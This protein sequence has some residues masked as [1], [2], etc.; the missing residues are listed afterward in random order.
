ALLSPPCASLCLQGALQAL[1]HS[2]SAATE[3]LCDAVIGHFVPPGPAPASGESPLVT[4]LEDAEQGRVLEAAL[5][6]AVP[7]QL[8]ELFQDH[9]R[10]RLRGVACHRLANHGLQ[11]LLDHA[12]S[13]VV[14][15]VLEE[16]GPALHEP[17]ARGHHGVAVALVAAC[18]RHPELQQGALR[19]VL[20][21]GRSSCRTLWCHKAPPSS[22]PR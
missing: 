4:A 3:H 2:Q 17:L 8:R 10:G 14:G 21:V 22:K 11:R 13:D 5:A 19:W 12:P 9:F 6:V 18:G 16:L 1:H 20:Q 7:Q 15:A